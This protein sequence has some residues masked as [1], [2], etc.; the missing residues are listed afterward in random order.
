M[1]VKVLAKFVVH[2]FGRFF[3]ARLC[4]TV[5]IRLLAGLLV[6]VYKVVSDIVDDI[7]D[8]VITC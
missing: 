3:L 1:F 6:T 2:V 4:F 7:L 5:L 8:K